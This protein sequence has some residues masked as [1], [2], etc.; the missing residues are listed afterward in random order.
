MDA[1]RRWDRWPS[2]RRETLPRAAGPAAWTFLAWVLLTWEFTAEQLLIGVVVALASGLLFAPLGK[3]AGP[4]DVLRPGRL[5]AAVELAGYTAW[6]IVV[7]NVRLAR[8]VWAPS[9]PL[10]SGM[11]VVPTRERDD[12]G[13]T[14]VALLTSMIV[15]NQ[16]AD[17]DARRGL[18]Q[19]HA[20]A[21]PDRPETIN[22]RVERIL[23]RTHPDDHTAGTGDS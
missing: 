8:R 18:L 3:G 2:V 12:T 20:V 19:Y 23:E 10:R 17:L 11:V 15:D 6:W 1:R 16:L 5:R 13:L 7:A 9:R 22:E 14:T 21:V 4:W